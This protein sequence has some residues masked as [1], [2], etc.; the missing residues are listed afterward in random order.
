MANMKS[1]CVQGVCY[2]GDFHVPIKRF[3]R[4]NISKVAGLKG[5][6]SSMLLLIF[7]Y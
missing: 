2:V 1:T 7:M 4:Q 3:L 6:Y 5:Q